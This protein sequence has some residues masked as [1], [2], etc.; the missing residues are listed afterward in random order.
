MA[1]RDAYQLVLKPKQSG[2]TV[3]SVKIAVD[4]KNGVPLRVQLLPAEGGKP[5]VDA[6][7]TKV[8]FAKPAADTF[9]FTPPKGAKVTEGAAGRARTAAATARSSRAWTPS[10]ASTP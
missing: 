8:D 9:A 10:P 6:G 7:F 3:G 2:S 1:G 5:I 4:A